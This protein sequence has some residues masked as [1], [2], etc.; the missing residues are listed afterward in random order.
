MT[1]R[2]DSLCLVI[3]RSMRATLEASALGLLLAKNPLNLEKTTSSVVS[4]LL[5]NY[6]LCIL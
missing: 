5:S 3:Q 1:S 6:D 4:S 2:T